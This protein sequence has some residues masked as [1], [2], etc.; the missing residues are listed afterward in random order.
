MCM[1]PTGG[2]GRTHLASMVWRKASSSSA[3]HWCEDLDLT[4]ASRLIWVSTDAA[5]SPPMT[6]IRELGHMNMNLGL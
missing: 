4:M 6:E 2:A 1:R 3:D 5:C